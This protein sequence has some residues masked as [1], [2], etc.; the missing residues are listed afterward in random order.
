MYVDIMTEKEN[1]RMLALVE[2]L[3]D[4]GEAISPEEEKLLKLLA[5]LIEDFEMRYYHPREATPL[6]IHS[7]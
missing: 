7:T 2:E 5:R 6:E 3:M 1:E 4:K